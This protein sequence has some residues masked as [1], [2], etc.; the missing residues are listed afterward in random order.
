LPLDAESNWDQLLEY[1]QQGLVVPVVGSGVINVQTEQG[2]KPYDAYLAERLAARVGVSAE[3]LPP[4]GELNEVA[5]RHV[6]NRGR[7]DELYTKVAK[8]AKEQTLPIPEA[9]LQLASIRAFRLFV[10]TSFSPFL[11]R[12]INEV[13][14]GGQS[15]TEVLTYS[16]TRFDDLRECI[17]ET[18]PPVVYHVLGKLCSIP[19]FALTHEDVLEYVHSLQS[20]Q[21]LPQKLY[22]EL[23]DRS[24]LILGCSFDD[25]LAR[26]FLRVYR[27]PRLSL[28]SPR[29]IF[30]ADREVTGD[31][32]LIEFLDSF[33]PGIRVFPVS[34][35]EEFVA[36]LHRRWND[37]HP[38]TQ[39]APLPAPRAASNDPY[40]FL[41]YASEDLEQARRINDALRSAKVDTFFDKEGLEAGD[42]WEVKLRKKVEGCSLFL[43]V[44]SQN[45]CANGVF[46][47]EWNLAFKIFEQ[48]TA[49]RSRDQDDVFLLPVEIDGTSPDNPRIREEFK[50]VQW[51]HLPGGNITPKFI[52]R[53]TFLFRKA[54]L[55]KGV[56]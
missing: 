14:F 8:L 52:E 3:G 24:I 38:S 26:F 2:S 33:G 50:E 51:E 18:C 7:L 30:V 34:G 35:P 56:H 29:P 37:L 12:A 25:W 21:R 44:I 47:W 41:S 6:A 54:Q 53:V 32:K 43:A 39:P 19:D 1:L 9:L 49:Y 23:E 36:E 15:K 45:V 17:S 40:V 16:L 20:E 11:E 48:S 31:S 55:E 27:R 46:R 42:N 28:G 5:C 4:G 10:T 22:R 13:Q